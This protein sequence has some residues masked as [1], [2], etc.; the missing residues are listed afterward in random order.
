MTAIHFAVKVNVAP[1]YSDG[2]GTDVARQATSVRNDL[3]GQRR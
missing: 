3:H 1:K 2:P